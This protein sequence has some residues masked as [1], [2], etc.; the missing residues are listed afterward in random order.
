ML[1]PT[2]YV[3]CISG[4]AT[5]NIPEIFFDDKA[6]SSVRANKSIHARYNLEMVGVGDFTPY[7]DEEGDLDQALV[8]EGICSG[9]IKLV[10]PNEY[11]ILNVP[12]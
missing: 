2:F 9:K 10:W 7:C 3:D 4:S 1:E 12:V 8:I 11:D 5:L 6:P